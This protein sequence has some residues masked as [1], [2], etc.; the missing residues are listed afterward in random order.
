MVKKY[1]PVLYKARSITRVKKSKEG[2][3]EKQLQSYIEDKL[4][5]LRISN[6]KMLF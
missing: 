2:R 4:T 5:T 3:T 1:I 6:R